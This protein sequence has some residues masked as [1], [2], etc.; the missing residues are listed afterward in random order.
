[1]VNEWEEKWVED[2]EYLRKNLVEKHKNL[3]FDITM[4]RFN[5]SIDKLKSMINELDYDDIKVELSKIVAS[6]RDAHTS[7]AFP[8]NKYMP[9]KLYWFEDGIYIIRATEKYKELLYNKILSIEGI[10]IDRVINRLSNIISFENEYFFKAQSMKYIQVAE[11]LY[12]LLIIDSIDSIKINTNHGEFVLETVS[13]NELAYARQELPLYS[14]RAHENFW[15]EYLGEEKRLYIK[16]NSCRED[17]GR[18]LKEKIN[19]AIKF[20]EENLIQ[21]LTIDLRNNLGGDS[22]LIAPLLEYIKSNNKI[23]KKENLEVIIGRETFSSGL[24]NAYEF[25]FQ[26]NAILTG[27]PSGGKPNCYGEVLKFKLPNSKFIVSYST[28]YYKLIE[29]DNIM[30]LCPDEVIYEKIEDY[31]IK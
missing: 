16:Y 29:D 9:I 7:I 31:L 18:T 15:Y 2:I 26:T 6:I 17:C 3:F 13:V 14:R 4:E 19:D 21:K 1:M 12:G 27:E 23:N 22:T 28:K 5:E 24:L 8:V 11:V 30:A 10:E 25:K 20:I